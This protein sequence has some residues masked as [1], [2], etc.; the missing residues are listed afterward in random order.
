MPSMPSHLWGG[1]LSNVHSTDVPASSQE[2]SGNVPG[3][4]VRCGRGLEKIRANG[5]T[6]HHAIQHSTNEES[7]GRPGSQGS[8]IDGLSWAASWKRFRDV[9]L[10]VAVRGKGLRL[11]SSL[12][13]GTRL[14]R[15][16]LRQR[17]KRTPAP[18]HLSDHV[19]I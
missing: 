17:Q 6:M 11:A 9:D 2:S 16:A 12:C 18:R 13:L 3:N 4:I 7:V 5:H 1:W 8:T 15:E 19:L 14:E 10:N